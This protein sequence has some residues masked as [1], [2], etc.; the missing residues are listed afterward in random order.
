MKRFLKPAFFGNLKRNEIMS[1]FF[2]PEYVRY[3][4]QISNRF[5]W[6]LGIELNFMN[7]NSTS[8]WFWPHCDS[9]GG[10][11][12]KEGSHSPVSGCLL[13]LQPELSWAGKDTPQ[14]NSGE[15]KE[16]VM[17]EPELSNRAL[18]WAKTL[19]IFCKKKY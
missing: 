1:I 16:V 19:R 8:K 4:L 10:S 9:L 2:I 12:L 6:C 11:R 3:T 7:W 18:S 5:H 15:I 17:A 14:N 13:A